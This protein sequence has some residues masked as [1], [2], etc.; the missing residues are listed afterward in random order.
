MPRMSAASV[1]ASPDPTLELIDKTARFL[2]LHRTAQAPTTTSD[3]MAFIG[4]PDA[5]AE[6]ADWYEG[7]G[8]VEPTT[9]ELVEDLARVAVLAR[10]AAVEPLSGRRIAELLFHKSPSA[11]KKGEAEFKQWRG[12]TR[13]KDAAKAVG[14]TAA[15]GE[16][17]SAAG[18]LPLPA[19]RCQSKI[20]NTWSGHRTA[21]IDSEKCRK[22][23]DREIG[24]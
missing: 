18:E 4:L 10:E 23:N 8:V 15:D 14:R 19:R 1:P 20:S 21:Q 2:K 9:G 11:C 16:R 13:W 24:F 22:I 3:P 7:C 17:L 6:F 12:K 5:V